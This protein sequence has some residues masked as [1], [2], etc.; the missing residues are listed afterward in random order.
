[1]NVQDILRD[2][3]FAVQLKQI[4]DLKP[5]EIKK[6][7]YRTM[8]EVRNEFVEEYANRIKKLLFE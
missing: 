3:T 8:S 7:D 2:M 1:M 6:E 4:D 5:R